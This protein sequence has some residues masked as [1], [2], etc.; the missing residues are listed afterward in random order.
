MP[1]HPP[2][3]SVS[4][5][6][7]YRK[8]TVLLSLAGTC[9][10]EPLRGFALFS[11]CWL[12]EGEGNPWCLICLTSSETSLKSRAHSP[13]WVVSS[14]LPWPI[15]YKENTCEN[16]INLT[17]CRR[18]IVWRRDCFFFCLPGTSFRDQRCILALLTIL[19]GGSEGV[20]PTLIKSLL[21]PPF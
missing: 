5:C 10:L 18:G 16:G 2:T 17:S 14:Q 3:P 15:T 1:P 8:R 13:R 20:V 4:P 11:H 6:P 9:E 19:G 12:W 7:P 21:S